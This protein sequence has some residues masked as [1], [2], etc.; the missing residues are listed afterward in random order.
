MTVGYS[1]V[2]QVSLH[3]WPKHFGWRG[4]GNVVSGRIGKFDQF[5][6]V[7]QLVHRT[8]VYIG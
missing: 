7:I 6:L 2:F 3:L 4:E 5:D 1:V 8:I